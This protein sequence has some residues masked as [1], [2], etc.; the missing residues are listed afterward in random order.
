MSISDTVSDIESLAESE[1]V[2]SG[3]V[4]S[5]CSYVTVV[6]SV[7]VI[8]GSTLTVEEAV[9]VTESEREARSEILAV[10]TSDSVIVKESVMDQDVD[11]L[12]RV[13]ELM[14]MVVVLV[15]DGERSKDPTCVNE[16]TECVVLRVS[17]F[18]PERV[19][20]GISVRESESLHVRSCV[21]EA[22]RV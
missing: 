13:A 1:M 14:N 20:V 15:N 3:V 12:D 22:V 19:G 6:V 2:S 8:G 17:S 21:I 16:P 9:L 7:S 5:V 10:R 18:D 4:D 11:S